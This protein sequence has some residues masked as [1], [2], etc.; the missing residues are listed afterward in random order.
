MAITLAAAGPRLSWHGA[1][2]QLGPRFDVR[3]FH[4]AVLDNG[5]IAVEPPRQLVA[6]YIAA[7]G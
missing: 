5:A 2:C 7:A 3:A 1:E 4:D 6:A